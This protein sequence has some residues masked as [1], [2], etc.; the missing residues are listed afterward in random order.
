MLRGGNKREP[1]ASQVQLWQLASVQESLSEEVLDGWQ[2][3]G[4]EYLESPNRFVPTVPSCQ[5]ELEAPGL[6]DQYD[7][8]AALPPH[9]DEDM[10]EHVSG[11]RRQ[12]I[13]YRDDGNDNELNYPASC[14]GYQTSGPDIGS[15]PR[16]LSRYS[17]HGFPARLSQGD[18]LT[19]DRTGLAGLCQRPPSEGFRGQYFEAHTSSFP[20]D[21]NR[22]P[23][24]PPDFGRSKEWE[25]RPQ[26]L[27]GFEYE[28]Q[29][30][31]FRQ[32][33]GD[34]E[35]PYTSAW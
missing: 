8:Q 3:Q 5:G 11:Q 19:E 28:L 30:E 16:V 22:E 2:N 6:C 4:E 21:Y 35:Y 31:Y 20:K 17:E 29:P 27:P 26:P 1:R 18:Y 25:Y 14:W 24:P 7:S 34:W 13:E 12:R 33:V 15:W 32:R 9:W 23:T 10:A